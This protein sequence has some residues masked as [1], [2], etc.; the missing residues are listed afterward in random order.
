MKNWIIEQLYPEYGQSMRVDEMLYEGTGDLQSL[1]VFHNERF[2]RV[3]TLD[4]IVQTTQADNFIYHE[5]LTHLPI[6]AHGNAKNVLIIGGG[7]GGM[8]YEALRHQSIEKVTMVEIDSAVVEFSKQ[9]LPMLSNGAFDDPRLNLIINDGALF[10]KET[11]D[12][13]DVIIVDSTDPIGPGEVLFTHEFY[14][15]AKKALTEEG[16]LVTQNGVPFMQGDE[17]TTSLTHFKS[18]FKD[19][20]AYTATIPTYAGGPMAFGWATDSEKHRFKTVEEIAARFSEEDFETHYYNPEVH[21]A[22][23]ALPQYIKKL[24]PV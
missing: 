1:K 14:S 4:N 10:M 12:K 2:G 16:I 23:F 17:L 19:W 8:A 3:L 22:A 9:H 7:D 20:S 18:L 24:F 6:I 15:D 11:K 21:V 5:M 13:Y